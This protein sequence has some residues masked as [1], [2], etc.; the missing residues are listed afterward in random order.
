MYCHRQLNFHATIPTY[1]VGLVVSLV[2]RTLSYVMC[3][4]MS[5][6]GHDNSTSGQI[7]EDDHVTSDTLN[8]LTL[9]IQ[10]LRTFLPEAPSLVSRKG[11]EE[12]G[13]TQHKDNED[14]VTTFMD[15]ALVSDWDRVNPKVRPSATPMMRPSVMYQPQ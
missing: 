14:Y 9:Y 4:M 5:T 2:H 12:D 15:K 8:K 6:L 3:H 1:I 13:V 10:Q 11:G 7:L